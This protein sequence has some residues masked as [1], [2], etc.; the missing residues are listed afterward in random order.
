MRARAFVTTTVAPGQVFVAMHFA[1]TNRLT[2]PS[3]DPHSRQPSYKASAVEVRRPR[4]G[5]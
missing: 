5:E 4:Q 2:H 3:F 1:E